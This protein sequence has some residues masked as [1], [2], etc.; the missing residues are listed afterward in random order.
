VI[1][2]D[3]VTRLTR[4]D[5]SALPLLRGP[6]TVDGVAPTVHKA[7][8]ALGEDTRAVLDRLGLTAEQIEGLLAAG[9]VTE[10]AD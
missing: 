4:R 5:G 2:L 6:I 1:H 9:I 8:P 3:M 7:P 10:P